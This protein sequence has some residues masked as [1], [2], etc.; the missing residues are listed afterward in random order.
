MN[1]GGR[2]KKSKRMEKVT[3]TRS[4]GYTVR[5]RVVGTREYSFGPCYVVT[6]ERGLFH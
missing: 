2:A 6:S 1:G 3:R 4:H 5:G